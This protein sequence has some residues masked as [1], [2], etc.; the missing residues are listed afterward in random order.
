MRPEEGK[1]EKSHSSLAGVGGCFFFT[2]RFGAK[3]FFFLCIKLSY[4]LDW[5]VKNIYNRGFFFFE[6]ECHF[7]V[8]SKIVTLY[9]RFL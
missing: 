8:I 3:R 5:L 1:G 9:P 7:N 6:P 2:A 4:S